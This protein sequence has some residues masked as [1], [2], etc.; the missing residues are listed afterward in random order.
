MTNQQIAAE[1]FTAFSTE[2]NAFIFGDWA[3]MTD[4]AARSAR[5]R[6]IEERHGYQHG[7]MTVNGEGFNSEKAFPDQFFPRF[8][9][10][11]GLS[12]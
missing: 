8:P 11:Q 12:D 7:W 3:R 1:R 10:D 4:V 9:V 2:M 5:E 6:E